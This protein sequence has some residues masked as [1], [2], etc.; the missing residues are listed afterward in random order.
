MMRL[1]TFLGCCSLA[2]SAMAEYVAPV[3]TDKS[4]VEIHVNKDWT[5]RQ[6]MEVVN[7]VEQSKGSRNLV[8][9]RSPTTAHMNVFE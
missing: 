7:K 9:K 8:S 4:L 1:F 2:A 6:R 5:V 3:S